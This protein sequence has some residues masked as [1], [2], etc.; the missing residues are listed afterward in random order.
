MEGTVVPVN[1][2]SSLSEELVNESLQE[3]KPITPVDALEFVTSP[4]YLNE[5][6]TPFQRLLLKTFYGLWDQYPPDEPE[7]LLLQIL[8]TKWHLKIDLRR[9]DP[10]TVMILVLGRR[11]TKSTSL[12]FLATYAAYELICMDNPQQH[13]GIRERH[14]IYITHVAAKSEQ[15]SAVFQYTYNN[16]RKCAFF[17]PFIDFDKDTTTQLRLCTPYDL[18]RNRQISA[19]NSVRL[20]GQV[21]ESLLPGSINIKSITTAS[22]TN[23]GDATYLLMF[24]ELAHFQ[25][26]RVDDSGIGELANDRTDY[27]VVEALVPS[28]KDF[29]DAGRVVM[30]SSPAEKGGEFYRHYCMG[31]G[32]EQ[33][34]AAQVVPAEGY[35]VI[36]LSTWEARP[37]ITRAMLQSAFAKDHRS[38]EKEYGAHFANPSAQFID[39][40]LI[41]AIPQPA[42]PLIRTNPGTWKFIVCVDPGGKAK[43]KVADTYSIAW[44]HV[45][46][47]LEGPYDEQHATYWIDGFEGFDLTIKSLQGGRIEKIPVDPNKVVQFLIDLTMGVGGR[48]FVQEICYD[49]WDSSAPISTLQGLGFP[50]IETTFT[51]EYKSDMYGNFLQKAEQ[52][53]VK[54]YGI[55]EAG[56]IERW[57]LEMKYLQQENN[58][59]YTYYHHPASGPV[60]HDDFADVAANLIHRLC[61]RTSPTKES[62]EEA[63]KSGT[64]PIQIR[65]TIVPSKGPN[66]AI[67][68]M[69]G[70]RGGPKSFRD[71]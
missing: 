52:R 67:P 37:S 64:G 70:R 63:R 41:L 40:A 18:R 53:Q 54:M 24:S 68:G 17:S 45:E 33:E 51:N 26:A 66:L 16:I 3:S 69:G 60:K 62:V 1:D 4:L 65:R 47:P 57:K 50:A 35:Q 10:V 27:A 46:Y 19:R 36:Q 28:T 6:P 11:S 71:R 42:R 2:F 29:G 20:R 44:G 23:R 12:S 9:P 8:E 48:N 61:L 22:T 15:A 13:F 25:R 56:W 21:K 34:G 7:L 5:N 59:R 49:Q 14:P 30:E 58:G 31:G 39:E 43:S 55:D 32:W 38:A